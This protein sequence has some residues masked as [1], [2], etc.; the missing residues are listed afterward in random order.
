MTIVRFRETRKSIIEILSNREME[1]LLR[2]AKGESRKSI[3]EQ[4]G[5]SVLTYDE[6]RKNIKQK[7]RLRT[8]ADWASA[9]VLFRNSGSVTVKKE[10]DK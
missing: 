10:I 4:L 5:I 2:L 3:S 7:L 6:H 8:Q 9:I 1:V